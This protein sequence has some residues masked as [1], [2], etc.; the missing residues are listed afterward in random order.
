MTTD[1]PSGLTA[2]LDAQAQVARMDTVLQ[3]MTR[4]AARW[5]V[6]SG[7]W[8]QPCHGVIVAQSGPPGLRVIVHYSSALGHSDVHPVRQPPRTR[9]ARSLVDAAAWMATDRGA[10][11]DRQSCRTDSA[12]RRRYL[13]AVWD[14]AGAGGVG[15]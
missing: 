10:Q 9:I 12:G 3:F 15:A 14:E 6:L 11:T 5:Q 2:L 4:D 7:R 8:Q 1:Y 13:D